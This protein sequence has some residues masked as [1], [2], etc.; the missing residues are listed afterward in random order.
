[1]T[2]S[3][4]ATQFSNYSNS[5]LQEQF[6]SIIN[7]KVLPPSNSAFSPDTNINWHKLLS[8]LAAFGSLFRSLI[9]YLLVVNE[10]T[11]KHQEELVSRLSDLSSDQLVSTIADY[12]KQNLVLP[13]DA[14]LHAFSPLPILFKQRENVFL[15][16]VTLPTDVD[17]DHI[18]WQPVTDIVLR[19][20]LNGLVTLSTDVTKVAAP[21][22]FC[23]LTNIPKIDDKTS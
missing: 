9:Q 12:E 21:F 15:R 18:W 2:T 20:A 23:E 6:D 5:E 7:T 14:Y 17:G 3:S 11:H 13:A 4:N 22:R 1:M 8:K 19:E 16:G 10:H